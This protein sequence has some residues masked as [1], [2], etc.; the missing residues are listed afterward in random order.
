MK[1]S[2]AILLLAAAA[3]TP[4][5]A[6]A[7]NLRYWVEPCTRPDTGCRPGDPQLAVWAL[8]AWQSASAGS[9]SFEKTADPEKA[10]LRFHWAGAREGL[11]GEAR[12]GDIYVRPAIVPEGESDALLRDVVVFLSCVHE[13]GH[14]LGLPHTADFADI[15]Y[16]FQYGGDI[17]EYFGRYRRL[18]KTRDDIRRHDGMSGQDRTRLRALFRKD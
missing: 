4:G 2:V 11:Y 7:A 16:S 18:L 6:R 14:A 10:Q 8:E 9:L 5:A 17:R 3:V 15:M 1:C 13:S 12:G